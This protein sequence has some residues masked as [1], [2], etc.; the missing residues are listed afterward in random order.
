[1]HAEGR[2][3]AVFA[4]APTLLLLHQDSVF[5][6]QLEDKRRYFIPCLAAAA[7]LYTMALMELSRIVNEGT[8]DPDVTIA[9]VVVQGL[10]ATL[11]SVPNLTMFLVYLWR[12]RKQTEW[13]LLFST[14]LNVLPVLFSDVHAARLLSAAALVGAGVQLVAMRRVRRRGAQL[15]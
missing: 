11:C 6:R 15:I 8:A 12:R 1:M 9:L 3:E 2:D 10:A 4:L 14:P 5:L 13:L 7:Y